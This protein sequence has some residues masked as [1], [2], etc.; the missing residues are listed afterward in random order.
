MSTIQDTSQSRRE[1]PIAEALVYFNH[2]STGYY[3][4]RT[5]EAIERYARTAMDPR[6]YDPARNEQMRQETRA[7]AAQLANSKADLV[8]F[9]SSLSESMNLFANGLDLQPGDNVLI[10]VEEFPSVTYPWVNQRI[11]RGIEV[12]RI[13]KDENGRT[14]IERIVAAMDERTRAVA[15]SHVEWADGYRNDIPALGKI[16]GERGIELFVD[17]TQSMGAQPIDLPAWGAT[18]IAAHVYKW[19]LAGHGLG[20][21]AFAEDA[22]ERIYPAYAG[23]HSFQIEMDDSNY[24][25]DDT[26]ST[27]E[28]RPGAHRY[29]TG[30]FDKLSMT[31]LNA[32]LSLILEVGPQ[33]AAAHGARLV[34]RIAA[35]AAEKG[36]EIVS[37]LSPEHRSQF[38]AITSRDQT[39][40]T[41]IVRQLA[42]RHIMVTLRPKGIR[43]APYF[44]HS[45]EDVERFLEALPKV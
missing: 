18:A 20:I 10:P 14:D 30:G 7:Q 11:R 6:S 33:H 37:D 19:L 35:G 44:Y 42:E 21:V 43:V 26:T 2:A 23:V 12:R 40:N 13:K 3:P 27:P 17:V 45:E 39:Q 16:C 32:S 9:T 41:D 24:S 22:I 5:V 28:F 38:L 4:L 34:D 1:F 8:A 29:Q 31:A 15:L 25:Y 36:F